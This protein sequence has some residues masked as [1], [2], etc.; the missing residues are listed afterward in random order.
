MANTISHSE[1]L[2]AAKKAVNSLMFNPSASKK[3]SAIEAIASLSSS[4]TPS[5]LR[6]SNRSQELLS[7]PRSRRLSKASKSKSK[8]AVRLRLR[9]FFTSGKKLKRSER[10]V[11]NKEL[12][13]LLR[14]ERL[15]GRLQEKSSK[16]SCSTT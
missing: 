3:Q 6:R 9:L 2:K 11:L 10:S 12:H 8:S 5:M 1:L 15:F 4:S 7:Q 14:R 16:K 13:A